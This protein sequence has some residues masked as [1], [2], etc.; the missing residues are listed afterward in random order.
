MSFV[1]TIGWSIRK[2]LFQILGQLLRPVAA[3]LQT[4]NRGVSRTIGSS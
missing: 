1:L 4:Q 2:E 3:A